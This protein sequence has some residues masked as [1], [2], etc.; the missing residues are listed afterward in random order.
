MIAYPFDVGGVATRVIEAGAGHRAIVFI[1]GLSTRADR[2]QA[3]L[4]PV[5][6][7]G[8]RAIAIDLPGHGFAARPADYPY[9]VP[10]YADFV[11]GLLDGLGIERADL[12]GTS[13]GGH[14]AAMAA[15]RAPERIGRAV[16]VGAVGVTPI[17]PDTAAAVRKAV[18][19]TDRD[20]IAAKL[21]TAFV[22]K[23][24]ITEALIE[25]DWRVNT[26]AGSEA[27]FAALGDYFVERLNDDVVGD[28]LRAYAAAHPVM[29]VW[30]AGDRI[31][32]PAMGEAAATAV[33]EARYEVLAGTGHAPYLEAPGRFN[34][35]LIDFL[36]S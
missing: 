15:C 8:R 21:D 12:V 16:L 25:E 5:A 27:A 7:S 6:A 11:L 29:L 34:P 26:M 3:N 19:R 36:E 22:V 35:L 24:L 32:P 9:G 17:A 4:G 18:T 13:L 1:H 30:G 14:V 33:P 20:G 10:A 28:R 2:W 31:V 23:S